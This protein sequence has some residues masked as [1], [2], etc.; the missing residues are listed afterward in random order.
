MENVKIT[1]IRIGGRKYNVYKIATT[2]TESLRKEV[3][4]SEE[5]LIECGKRFKYT[6]QSLF[7]EESIDEQL[8][9]EVMNL[10]TNKFM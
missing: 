6:L 2:K 7:Q 4:L 5:N 1:E 10:I 9:P 3:Y 8:L